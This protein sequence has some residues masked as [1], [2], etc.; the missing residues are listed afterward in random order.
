MINNKKVLAVVPARGGSKGIPRKNIKPLRGKPLIAWT[1]EEAKKSRFLDKIIVSTEDEE[2]AMIAKDWGAEVPF[3][4]PVELAQDETPGIAP[5]L[6]AL[7]Y[8]V[9]YEY[10]VVLQPTSP[11]RKAEDIDKA[12][13]LCEQSKSK[14]CVSVTESDIIPEWMFFIDNQGK[15]VPLNSDYAG[16]PYQRQNAKK[17]YILNGAVYV[18]KRSALI[19]SGSFLTNNTIPYIMPISRSVDIDDIIDFQWCEY[20][21]KDQ[22]R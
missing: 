9:D 17:T 10:V 5:V 6:H 8:F 19:D 1:I 12:I 18:G 2:V 20:I 7:D 22:D 14:F 16:I 11:L 3:L 21:L 15:L 4:R 13:I